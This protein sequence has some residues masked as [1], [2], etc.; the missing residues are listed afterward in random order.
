MTSAALCIFCNAETAAES[1]RLSE[2]CRQPV[3]PTCHSEHSSASSLCPFCLSL[4]ALDPSPPNRLHCTSQE[5]QCA[6]HGQPFEY[7]CPVCCVGLCK[8]CLFEQYTSGDSTHASHKL[9]KVETQR[10][11]V[12]ARIAEGRAL[13][14]APIG[15]LRDEL[16]T[17]DTQ[18]NRLAVERDGTLMLMHQTFKGIVERVKRPFA[19]HEGAVQ[20]SMQGLARAAALADACVADAEQWLRSDDGDAAAPALLAVGRAI[21]DLHADVARFAAVTA[22]P[23]FPSELA[24]PFEHF[25]TEIADVA[26]ASAAFRA[27]APDAVRFVYSRKFRLYG[28]RW[29]M[30][31]YPAGNGQGLNTHLA[32][33]VE[34]LEGI[35]EP[36]LFVYEIEIRDRAGEAFRRSYTSA[37]ELMDSWGWNRLIALGELQRFIGDDGAL[38]FRIGIRPETYQEAV[39]AARS[40]R[41]FI[42]ARIEKSE[43]DASA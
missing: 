1:R 30:K 43:E 6:R 21:E 18:T 2:C 7:Y 5:T 36:I 29:R 31:T 15:E 23:G 4:F 33:F 19:E 35:A 34:L 40:R 28:A 38:R 22:I 12:V 3:C 13:L 17:I 32:T 11:S 25:E 8:D 10:P 37:F 24:P 41:R 20:A 9:L 16:I 27:A 14:A 26:A 42:D 39:K